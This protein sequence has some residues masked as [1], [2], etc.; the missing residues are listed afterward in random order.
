MLAWVERKVMEML[1]RCAAKGRETLRVGL[2]S[3][4]VATNWTLLPYIR[5]FGVPWERTSGNLHLN[6]GGDF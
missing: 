1:A 2:V 6:C 4:P 5:V 3:S